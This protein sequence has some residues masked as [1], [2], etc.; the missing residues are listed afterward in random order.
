MTFFIIH[1]SPPF[2]NPRASGVVQLCCWQHVVS[3]DVLLAAAAPECNSTPSQP[4][5]GLVGT[6][7]RLQ[8]DAARH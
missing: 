2:S 3:G 1:P 6:H 7:K 5:I 8:Q 4:S